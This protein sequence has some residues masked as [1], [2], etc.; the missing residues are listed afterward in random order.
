MGGSAPKCWRRVEAD[1]AMTLAVMS[2]LR[3]SARALGVQACHEGGAGRAAEPAGVPSV[4]G[5]R[6]PLD[7]KLVCERWRGF[8]SC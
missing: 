2:G 5:L 6:R 7:F 3:M 1:F 4:R 8:I